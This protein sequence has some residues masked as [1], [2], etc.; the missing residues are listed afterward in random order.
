[1]HFSSNQP[2]EP[3]VYGIYDYASLLCHNHGI[4]ELA[5]T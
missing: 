5:G 4:L 2:L 1:M 3:P